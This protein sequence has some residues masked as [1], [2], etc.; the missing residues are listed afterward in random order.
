MNKKLVMI[1]ILLVIIALIGYLFFYGKP[2]SFPNNAQAIKAMNELYA[3]ANVG[4]ISDVIPLD[5][6]H[7]FV[8]FISGDNLYGMSFWVWDRFQWKLGRIDTRGEPYIWK[9]NERDASTHYIVWNM[10]PK[11][12]LRELKY[13]L[14][15]ERDFHSSAS[16]ET[17]IP[18]IQIEKTISLQKKNYGVLPFP[19]EWAELVNRN[20][21]LSKANQPPSLFQMNTPSSTMYVGWIP[22]GE[23]GKV[24]F[25]ENT[26]NGSSFDSDGINLDFVRILN[27]VELEIP[28]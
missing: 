24:V 17:Y 9:I 27:E 7:V 10:D 22:Y 15:G 23:L 11:D 18:R 14:I 13:Y 2:T 6:R 19:K 28:K 16:L 1:P 12:E 25:P 3:E 5:S 26:V 4:I 20:L 21:R 8:P